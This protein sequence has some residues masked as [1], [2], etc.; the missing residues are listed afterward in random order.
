[1]KQI[2]QRYDVGKNALMELGGFMT[3]DNG[4]I[5]MDDNGIKVALS[6]C[7][8]IEDVFDILPFLGLDENSQKIVCE[9]CPSLELAYYP[10]M[11]VSSKRFGN[12]KVIILRHV[13]SHK[14][15]TNLIS[16]V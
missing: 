9:F 1:M 15:K 10:E 6:T 14:H 13:I 11:N 8:N 12:S 2:S 5:N 4:E 3:I 16:R 7:K